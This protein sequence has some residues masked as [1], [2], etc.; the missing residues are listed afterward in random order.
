M[1]PKP[2]KK[3]KDF[4]LN[5][6]LVLEFEKYAPSGKQTVIVESLIR[7]WVLEQRRIEQEISMRKAYERLNKN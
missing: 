6:Q 7:E 4:K 1:D 5:E 2:V 3:K